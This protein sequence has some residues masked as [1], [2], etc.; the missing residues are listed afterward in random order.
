MKRT[1]R[2]M[3]TFAFVLLL[4]LGLQ[5][6]TYAAQDGQIR[7]VTTGG[8]NM[9]S[10]PGSSYS[11]IMT[12]S[13]GEALAYQSTSGDWDYFKGWKY[14]TSSIVNGY[15]PSGSA[16]SFTLATAKYALSIY[17]SESD[18]S[19]VGYDVPANAYLNVDTMAFNSYSNLYYLRLTSYV[20]GGTLN[21]QN[22]YVHTNFRT[23]SPSNYY[24]NI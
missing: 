12:L 24:I 4:L 23:S 14:T 11:V 18:S 2:T 21:Y 16:V 5:V 15:V 10:G 20:S 22:G 1:K 7:K 9:R 17:S 8:V 3:F 19:Y 13:Q 6:P